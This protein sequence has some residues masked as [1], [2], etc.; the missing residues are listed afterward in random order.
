IG[1]TSINRPFFQLLTEKLRAGQDIEWIPFWK[2]FGNMTGGSGFEDYIPPH[3]ML[4][5]IL[6]N[7]YNQEREAQW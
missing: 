4:G 7:A 5:A 3:Q 6:L 2:Q 1:K